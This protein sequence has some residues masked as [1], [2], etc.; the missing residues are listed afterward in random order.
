MSSPLKNPL[1]KHMEACRVPHDYDIRILRLYDTPRP[2]TVAAP[3]SLPDVCCRGKGAG[4]STSHLWS[5]SRLS[6]TRLLQRTPHARDAAAEAVEMEN[7]EW[8]NF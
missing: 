1:L 2:P 8:E 7:A 4:S 5:G 6:H 3:T